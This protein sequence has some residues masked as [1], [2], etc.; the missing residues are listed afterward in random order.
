MEKDYR[1][2]R[3]HNVYILGAGFSRDAGL[4]LIFDF[5]DQMRLGVNWI[6]DHGTDKEREAIDGVFKFRH[7]AAGAAHRARIDLENIEELFSLASAKERD[8]GNDYVPRAIAATLNYARSTKEPDTSLFSVDETKFT[9]PPTWEFL[10]DDHDRKGRKLYRTS[11]YDAYAGILSGVF[12]NDVPG[13]R[14]TI[15]TFNYDTLLEDS[16]TNLQVPFSYQL[17]LNGADY[18]ASAVHIGAAL[19][20]PTALQ[21][22]K[23]HGSVNW[24]I[25][26]ITETESS[27]TVY[28][29]YAKL[30]AHGEHPF[31]LPPTWRK[32]FAGALAT[33]WTGALDAIAEATR[34]IVIGFSMPR[35]DV[36]FKYLL[37]AGLRD[38][39]SL[40]D[41]IFITKTN[42]D[43]AVLSAL[44]ENVS[45]AFQPTLTE[46]INWQVDG[47]RGALLNDEFLAQIE[48][49]RSPAL[50]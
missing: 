12:C 33:V 29:D 21:V 38:N 49:T 9:P 42:Y 43:E 37:A 3:S 34:I 23:L 30:N 26:R 5:L 50:K 20:D 14:N 27:L 2:H 13:M 16:L 28:G 32:V 48:R 46:K 4:P 8:E 35:T 44:K 6:A 39:I 7:W 40:R 36:H 17:P 10:F 41:V 22:L 25:K 11:V 19:A 18:D 45:L 1:I 47:V 31:L 15:I 24:A